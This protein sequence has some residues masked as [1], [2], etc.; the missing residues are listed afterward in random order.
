MRRRKKSLRCDCQCT[1]TCRSDYF[2]RVQS[3]MCT[4]KSLTISNLGD[5]L[6]GLTSLVGQCDAQAKKRRGGREAVK[7]PELPMTREEREAEYRRRESARAE[8]KTVWRAIFAAG[9]GLGP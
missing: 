6:L 9:S 5:L 1:I 2:L 7:S 4:I 3:A 8:N